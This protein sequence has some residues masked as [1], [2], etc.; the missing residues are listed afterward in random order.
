MA[1][2]T[3]IC[4]FDWNAPDFSLPGTDGKAYAL[5][6]IRGKNGTLIIFMCNHC[7]YVLAILERLI[8]DVRDLQ[9]LGIG[10][11]A[12]NANDPA[13][14]PADSFENMKKMA[15]E[16]DFTFPYLFDENQDV[17]RAFDAVCTPDFFGFNKDLRLQY[18]GRLD[19]SKRD[20]APA[21]AKR[22]LFEAMALVA[23]S[24]HGPKAQIPS[25]GCSI[26]WKQGA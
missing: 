22:E 16:H 25:M 10:V 13:Q 24:G 4:N 18:R 7:P 11:A 20:T 26:K 6:D 5:A 8:R 3:P 15:V 19:A 9:A 17:A 23:N 1:I 2:E 12:I 21:D 14:Y